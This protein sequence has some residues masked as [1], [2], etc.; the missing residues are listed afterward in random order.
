MND[1]LVDAT[2]VSLLFYLTPLWD[3]S[4]MLKTSIRC[5]KLHLS[6]KITSV[7]HSPEAPELKNENKKQ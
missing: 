4:H 1:R 3:F 7:V 5:C 6:L 2:G